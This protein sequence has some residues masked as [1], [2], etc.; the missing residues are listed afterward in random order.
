M[1]NGA[2]FENNNTKNLPKDIQDRKEKIRLAFELISKHYQSELELRKELDGKAGNLI[3]YVTI[4]TGLLIGL[5]TFSIIDSLQKPEYYLPY[6]VGIASLIIS[7]VFSLGAVRV[8]KWVIVPDV[9]KLWDAVMRDPVF[10]YNT[11]IKRVGVDMVDAVKSNHEYNE[12]KAKWT[13]ISWYFLVFGLILIVIFAGIFI[14][15]DDKSDNEKKIV[16]T[17]DNESLK[18]IETMLMK[19]KQ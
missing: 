11:V 9:E 7:I 15:T 14:T 10:T 12:Q 16:I 5:G 2:P 8:R 17:T 1:S 19:F 18:N 13:L 3:G 4:V 6:F